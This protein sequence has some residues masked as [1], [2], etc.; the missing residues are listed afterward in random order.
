MSCGRGR[1]GA[2]SSSS[3]QNRIYALARRHDEESSPD[4]IIGILSVSSYDI[5]ALIDPGSTLSY[6][7]PLVAA[8]LGHIISGE[9]TR[10]DTQKIEAVKTWPRPTT[11]TEVRSFLGLAGNYRR[12]VE[13][14][15]SL[16]APLTKLTR[17]GARF[18]WTDACEWSFQALKDRLTSAPVLTLSEGTD[19]YVIYCDASGI[20]LGCV[21]MQHGTTK[22]YHDI[23]E[24]YLWDGMKKNIA[25]FVAQCPNYRG[26][27][28][29]ANFWR[30]FQNGL[31]TQV[32]LSTIFHPQ[33]DGQPESTIQTLEDILRACVID[34]KGSWDDHLP[35]IE[36]TYN[37]SYHSNIQMAPYEAL[38]GRKSQS[39]QKSYSDVRQ[40]DLE[41]GVDDWVFLKVSP[42]KGVMR[43]GKKGKLSLWCIGPYR[44]IR[45][46]GQV[47]YELELPSELDSVHPIFHVSILQKCIGDLT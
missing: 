13:G 1:G 46:V 3:P 29:T 2:S 47:A 23:R 24:V 31:G 41:F 21:L 16:S 22:M 14:F 17:K 34:F 11:S 40:Q 9:G 33:T 38:Y 42:I 45:R 35:L 18:Q 30:S 39:R 10:V 20:G 37:Y 7:T 43:F 8:F 4:V 25:E 36:F 26:A 19:G 27:Q 5:Y 32:S 12:F 15:S 44:I 6:V 28:F